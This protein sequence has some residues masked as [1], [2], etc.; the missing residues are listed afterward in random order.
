MNISYLISVLNLYLEKENRNP[1]VIEIIKENDIFKINFSYLNTLP[2]KTYLK[3][4]EDLFYDNVN[5]IMKKIKGNLSL[6]N[7]T[8]DKNIYKIVFSNNRQITFINF[9][10]SDLESIRKKIDYLNNNFIFNQQ[11]IN[12][13]VSYNDLYKE[14]NTKS[15]SLRPSFGFAS[16]ITIFLTSI[17]FLDIFMISLWI[18]KALK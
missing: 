2:N 4:K 7:E 9:S 16:F 13:N 18:F 12:T 11:E 1:L 3:I 8:I 15:L 17:W 5:Y 10:I 6:L 14:E